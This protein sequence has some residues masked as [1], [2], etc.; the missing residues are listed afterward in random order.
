MGIGSAL[1]VTLTGLRT[2]QSQLDITANNI[3]NAGNA[4][5]SRKAINTQALVVGSVVYGVAPAQVTRELNVQVQR[6]WRLGA[7]AAEYTDV[8]AQM[9]DRLQAAFGGPAD[10]GSLDKTFNRFSSAM[11]ALSTSPDSPIKRQDVIV[12]AS[13]FAAKIRDLSNSVQELRQ[14]AESN[15]AVLTDEANTLLQRIAAIDK[16]IVATGSGGNSTAG[17]DDERDA[18][19][20]RLSQLFDIRVEDQ[21]YGAIAIY[22]TGGTLLYDDNPVQFYFDERSVVSAT[23]QWSSDPAERNVGTLKIATGPGAGL[24]LFADDG[25]RAGAIAAYKEL[26]DETLVQAQ[27]QLDELAA[28]LSQ[29]L[30][31]TSVEG[32]AVT[33]PDDGFSLEVGGIVEGDVISLDFTNG[34]GAQR[35]SLV[36][37]AGSF[38]GDDDYTAVAGDTVHAID[39]T[40]GDAAIQAD[41]QTALGAN[42]TVAYS[43]GTLTVTDASGG[44]I[45]IDG[46]SARISRTGLQDDKALPLFVDSATLRPYTGL[47]DGSDNR[48]GLSSRLMVNPSVAADPAYLVKYA[49]TTPEGDSARPRAL[50]SALRETRFSYDPQTGLGSRTAPYSGSLQTFLT[51]VVT[52]QGTQATSARQMADGQAIVAANLA[53]RYNASREVD[54]DT[55]MAA[56][57]ELQTAYQANARVMTAAREMLDVLMNI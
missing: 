36:A 34:S 32:T 38:T 51:Q 57:I 53:E 56:L 27:R 50:L 20:D 14:D 55:E 22:T 39:F 24:D 49:A 42:F 28:R 46:L 16:Q 12:A 40:Q 1:N 43:G 31:Q 48:L 37:T 23:S 5:Y 19:V 52:H 8:R 41:I 11:E 29:A 21:K 4:N 33:V 17:L 44:A 13:A 45:T 26:R 35:I 25:L 30:A 10:P 2:A 15:I 18:A 3:A 9:L 6:Q 7:G 47:V 54:I